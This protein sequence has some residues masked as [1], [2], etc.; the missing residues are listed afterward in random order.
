MQQKQWPE[1]N[2][3]CVC[4]CACEPRPHNPFLFFG[5][6]TEARYY[7]TILDWSEKEKI[8]KRGRKVVQNSPGDLLSGFRGHKKGMFKK[9]ITTTYIS[10]FLPN[11]SF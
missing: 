6:N 11:I 3:V 1:M 10:L 2:Q 4:V 5:R 8:G 7:S 9:T